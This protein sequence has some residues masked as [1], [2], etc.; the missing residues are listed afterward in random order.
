MM[1][2]ILFFVFISLFL[3]GLS[4]G[5]DYYVNPAADDGGDGTTTDTT[6]ANCAWNELSD[7]SVS[8]GDTVSLNKGTGGA[9]VNTGAAVL[10][11]GFL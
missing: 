4:F 7:I 10:A 1:K 5:T 3:C 6:G 8:A 2:R 11:A 9:Y